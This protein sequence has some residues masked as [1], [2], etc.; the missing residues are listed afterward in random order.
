MAWDY[1]RYWIPAVG[2]TY[3]TAFFYISQYFGYFGIADGFSIGNVT[4]LAPNFFLKIG[5]G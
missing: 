4:D 3:R 1:D 2:H 5:A